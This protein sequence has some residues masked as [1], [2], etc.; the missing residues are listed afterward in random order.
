MSSAHASL[1]VTSA[2]FVVSGSPGGYG[3]PLPYGYSTQIVM[4]GRAITNS[5]TNSVDVPPGTNYQCA[6]WSGSGSVPSSGTSNSVTFMLSSESVLTWNWTKQC[7]LDLSNSAGGSLDRQ[8][9]W[10]NASSSVTVN[11]SASNYYY[12]TNWSGSTGG[13]SIAGNQITAPMSQPR[14][15]TGAFAAELATNNVPKWWL[16]GYGLTN[17]GVDATGD[18][19]RDMSFTWEEYIA[20]TDPTTNTSAFLLVAPIGAPTTASNIVIRWL[21]SSNRFYELRRATNL[22][23]GPNGFQVRPGAS[24]LPGSGTENSYTDTVSGTGPFFYRVNVHQ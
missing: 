21:S 13:C 3:S 24:G 18:V 14:A 16:A 7:R 17:F 12:F 23:E 9:G 8:S 22:I 20:G 11:A 4:L 15:I 1:V 2:E 10:V 19:D 5:V 6:G